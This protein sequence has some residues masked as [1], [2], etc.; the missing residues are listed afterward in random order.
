MNG[1]ERLSKVLR[2]APISAFATRENAHAVGLL[3]SEQAWPRRAIPH[4]LQLR[5]DYWQDYGGSFVDYYGDPFPIEDDL[6]DR[7]FPEPSC[8]WLSAF[9]KRC[10]LGPLRQAP[11][12]DRQ[13]KLQ[14]LE[15]GLRVPPCGYAI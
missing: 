2:A 13:A 14:I 10:E 7:L 12:K 1:N 6:M 15:L 8:R 11:S 5:F 3:L 9:P 4:I